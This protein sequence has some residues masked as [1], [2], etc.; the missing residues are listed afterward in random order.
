LRPL[1]VLSQTVRRVGEGDLEARILIA[2]S[3]ELAGLARDINTMTDRLR[4]YRRSSLGELL[5]AQQAAQAAIDSLTDPVI[6]FNAAGNVINAN[7]S[8]QDLFG[9]DA[10]SRLESARV[11]EGVR[12]T[13]E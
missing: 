1:G 2:G 5:E 10:G 12:E 13:V 4:T 7:E 9:L 11:D 3:D 8:A 6:V